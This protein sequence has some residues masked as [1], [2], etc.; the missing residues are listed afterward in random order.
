MG[1]LLDASNSPNN[2]VLH[3]ERAYPNLSHLLELDTEATLD[4]LKLAF[5][6]TEVPGAEVL[7]PGGADARETKGDDH[8]TLDFQNVLVQRTVDVLVDLIGKYSP[9]N[10]PN[11]EDETKSLEIWPA[12][13]DQGY[14]FEFIAY[15]VV[16]QRCSV[17]RTVICQVLEYLASENFAPADLSKNKMDVLKKREKQILSLLEVVPKDEW[18]ASYVLHL[19]E[20]AHFFQVFQSTDIKPFRYTSFI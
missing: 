18:D 13:K 8:I 19:C 9:S 14:V 10:E 15:N 7:S 5:V 2:S 16:H 4:V 20:R 3:S 11:L 1:F 6:E 12:K 17:S